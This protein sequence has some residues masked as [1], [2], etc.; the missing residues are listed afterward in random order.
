MEKLAVAAASSAAGRSRPRSGQPQPVRPV[1]PRPGA[2]SSRRLADPIPPLPARPR[3]ATSLTRVGTVAS[4]DHRRRRPPL[5][6]ERRRQH[7][8]LTV[9]GLSRASATAVLAVRGLIPDIARP[10]PRRTL[11]PSPSRRAVPHRRAVP[12]SIPATGRSMT[13]K[14]VHVFR[15]AGGRITEHWVRSTC[16]ASCSSSTRSAP[17]P[18][19]ASRCA[20]RSSCCLTSQVAGAVAV[21]RA[22]RS[23]GRLRSDGR[24]G[25]A[26]SS[27]SP[28]RGPWV[29]EELGRRCCVSADFHAANWSLVQASS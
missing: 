18:G 28:R 7:S 16:L 23:P 5:G 6:P 24:R 26:C 25:R 22:R 11:S 9:L 8:S 13:W 3:Q 2:P 14:E 4:G 15:C 1:G 10:S 27:G 17:D 21:H 20:A 12:A 19:C 29:G